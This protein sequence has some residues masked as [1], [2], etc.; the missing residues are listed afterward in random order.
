MSKLTPIA[1]AAAILAFAGPLSAAQMP[2]DES[3]AANVRESQQYEQLLR[4]NPAFR[5][6]RIKEE[7]GPITDPQMHQQCVASFG[8]G[9]PARRVVRHR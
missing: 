5:A 7:C 8:P 4:S 6:K 1:A 2:R 9:A 3:A